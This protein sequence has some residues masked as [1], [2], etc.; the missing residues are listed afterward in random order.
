MNKLNLVCASVLLFGCVGTEVGNPAQNNNVPETTEVSIE[1]VGYQDLTRNAL[2]LE[3]GIEI[4]EAWVVFDE[5]RFQECLDDDNTEREDEEQIDDEESGRN[6]DHTETGWL[7]PGVV[8]LTSGQEYP[9]LLATMTP[10]N[11]CGIEFDVKPAER[12]ELSPQ[13][14]TELGTASVLIRGRTPTGVKFE[15]LGEI[16]AEFSLEGDI[17]MI[18]GEDA[19]LIGFA[20]NKWFDADFFKETKGDPIIINTDQHSDWLET[21]ENS[22]EES[23]VLYRDANGDGVLGADESTLK[24]GE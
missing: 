15:L 21:F 6:D 8:E 18:A 11:Y 17:Q 23:A 9:A 3:N 5:L 19:F 4:E 24:L 1:F 20:L 7:G 13:S 22:F 10:G 16:E 12:I 14:P 2:S